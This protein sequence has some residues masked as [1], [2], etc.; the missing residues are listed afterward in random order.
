MS[1]SGQYYCVLLTLIAIVFVHSCW[2]QYTGLK[3][4]GREIV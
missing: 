1:D 3:Y 4:A 2:D